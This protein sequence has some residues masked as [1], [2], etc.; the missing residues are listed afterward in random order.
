ML[1]A[2]KD[3]TKYFNATHPWVNHEALLSPCCIG[4]LVPTVYNQTKTNTHTNPLNKDS[5]TNN[6]TETNASNTTENNINNIVNV[7]QFPAAD[8]QQMRK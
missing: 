4:I 1:V 2:G 5:E 7:T 3:A 6:N 8:S